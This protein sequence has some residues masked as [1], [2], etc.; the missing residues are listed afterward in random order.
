MNQGK[1]IE[2]LDNRVYNLIF[3]YGMIWSAYY[4]W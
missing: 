2:Q 3:V 4:M 1:L